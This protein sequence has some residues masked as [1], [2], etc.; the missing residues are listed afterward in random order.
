[1]REKKIFRRSV[2]I[3]LGIICARSVHT[4]SNITPMCARRGGGP[5][6]Q[7]RYRLQ[8]QIMHTRYSFRL[9]LFKC[10]DI[11]FNQLIKNKKR[12]E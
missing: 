6:L 7:H 1:M 10:V 9:I 2:A 5:T 4:H 8:L 11:S 3:A 12:Y